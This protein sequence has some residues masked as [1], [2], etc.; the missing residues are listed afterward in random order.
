MPVKVS[1][2]LRGIV[3]VDYDFADQGFTL[4]DEALESCDGKLIP[5]FAAF[6][7][8]RRVGTAVLSYTGSGLEADLELEG[9]DEILR[10]MVELGRERIDDYWTFGLGGNADYPDGAWFRQPTVTYQIDRFEPGA[11]GL[12]PRK[13]VKTNGNC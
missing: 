2:S 7:L 4:S 3:E 10:M 13:Q 11:L 8:D 1:H 5:V 12:F 6:D 9:E